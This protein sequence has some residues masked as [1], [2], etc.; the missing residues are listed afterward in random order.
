M[1]KNP[2]VTGISPKEGP[3]GTKVTIRGE[4]LGNNH[5]D[6]LSNLQIINFK[7]T[8]ESQLL[9]YRSSRFEDMRLRVYAFSRMEIAK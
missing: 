2:V 7:L 6:L 9:F 1:A 8:L 5:N 4:Y 3:P